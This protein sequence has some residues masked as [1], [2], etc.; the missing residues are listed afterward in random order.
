[1]KRLLIDNNNKKPL[2]TIKLIENNDLFKEEITNESV[3]EIRSLSKETGC[4]YD[5]NS[6]I[7]HKMILYIKE[8]FLWLND[9]NDKIKLFDAMFMMKNQIKIKIEEI[10]N[11]KR[12]FIGIFV[13]SKEKL[14]NKLLLN[15]L[16][17]TLIDQYKFNKFKIQDD[18]YLINNND[19]II[20][21]FIDN[22]NIKI[23]YE[24]KIK[25][26]EEEPIKQ[27]IPLFNSIG[28]ITWNFPIECLR[29]LIIIYFLFLSEILLLKIGTYNEI[30]KEHLQKFDEIKKIFFFF[31]KSFDNDNDINYYFY[32]LINFNNKEDF[33]KINESKSFLLY[34]RHIFIYSIILK[35][36][37]ELINKNIYHV[38]NTNI[39]DYNNINANYLNTFLDYEEFFFKIQCFSIINQ[40]NINDIII[41]II[42]RNEYQYNLISKSILLKDYDGKYKYESF[43]QIKIINDDNNILLIKIPF[44]F[45]IKTINFRSKSSFSLFDLIH[46]KLDNSNNN[47]NNKW[48]GY[49][50]DC[51]IYLLPKTFLLNF[52]PKFQRLISYDSFMIIFLNIPFNNNQYYSFIENRSNIDNLFKNE[53][54]FGIDGNYS[55]DNIIKFHNNMSNDNNVFKMMIKLKNINNHLTKIQYKSNN[56]NEIKQ[57]YDITD[58]I[59][60]IEDLVFSP[61]IKNIIDNKI[62]LKNYDRM[63][64]INWLKLLGYKSEDITNLFKYENKESLEAIKNQ[65]INSIKKKD[66]QPFS[67]HAFFNT[68]WKSNHHENLICPFEQEYRKTRNKNLPQTY[69]YDEKDIILGKCKKSCGKSNY[70]SPVTFIT[71]N[72]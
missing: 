57:S 12:L 5:I 3:L 17:W 62:H 28:E 30:N 39:L 59:P 61:C 70:Y 58:K 42:K 50:S 51:H 52:L 55:I 65:Y 63:T 49:I 48:F 22:P 6:T 67:C 53:K 45:F 26:E 31:F 69:S 27:D 60:N 23:E 34:A 14:S 1:M 43:K 66:S 37:I 19:L 40:I 9:K 33:N 64:M 2:K 71:N 46:P 72:V 36:P 7:Y 68:S 20:Y 4:Y 13:I 29:S 54:F 21:N 8:N 10:N 47:N 44:L 15:L 35:N 11:F 18:F 24:N 56:K 38:F 41:D 25:I 32:D 16:K